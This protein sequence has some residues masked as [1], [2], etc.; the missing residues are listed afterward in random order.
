MKKLIVAAA[1]LTIVAAIAGT[2]FAAPPNAT[3]VV[4][5]VI[6]G[7]C[8]FDTVPALNLNL[9][10]AAGGPATGTANL[11]FWCTNGT[12]WALSD[13]IGNTGTYAGTL[14]CTTAGTCGANT[15]S[16]TL[17]Y[18]NISGGPTAGRTDVRTSVL[19]ATVPLVNFQDLPQGTYSQN[20]TFTIA[21]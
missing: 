16:Y 9:D 12:S 4:T 5:G 18:N 21:P 11:T 20:V 19:T 8:H 3:V 17:T 1:V 13:P 15:I 7:V 2:A 14:T 6:P 10:P